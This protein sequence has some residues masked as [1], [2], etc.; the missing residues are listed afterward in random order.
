MG[1]G[2]SEKDYGVIMEFGGV[3]TRQEAEARVKQMI[4]EAFAV[5]GL[6]LAKVMTKG[7]EHRVEKIGCVFAA[8]ALWY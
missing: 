6:K 7:V 5:R 2:F 8:V 4:E 1:V 3:C